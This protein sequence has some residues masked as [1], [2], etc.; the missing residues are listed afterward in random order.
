MGPTLWLSPAA[1]KIA[2]DF[3]G[4]A[5]QAIRHLARR[6]LARAKATGPPF[7]PDVLAGYCAIKDIVSRSI[8][9]DGLLVRN[10]DGYS[11]QINRRY[12]I[13]S[14]QWNAICAHELGHA[15]LLQ[16]KGAAHRDGGSTRE[17]EYLCDLAA[18]ELLLPMHA[19]KGLVTDQQPSEDGFSI[20]SLVRLAET[21]CAPPRM[22]AMRLVE[23]GLWKG[24]AMQWKPVDRAPE[25]LTLDW[26]F[27]STGPSAPPH[28]RRGVQ[29]A[30]LFGESNR[31]DQ[32]WREG[33]RTFGLEAV[34]A[35]QGSAWWF[36]RSGRFEECG[37]R[38][39]LSLVRLE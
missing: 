11:I 26:W 14:G 21:F 22:T 6:L 13:R 38:Y 27:P 7:F 19:F 3:H 39:V 20:E 1:Q 37:A 18:R 31:I 29:A 12:P 34:R 5:E 10:G 16:S 30:E 36:V 25:R 17:E 35:R 24:F 8:R 23:C 4:D 15:I 33:A 28:L 2:E 32:A 9:Q